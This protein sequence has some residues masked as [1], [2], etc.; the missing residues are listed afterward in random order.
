MPRISTID[1]TK[2]TPESASP[3]AE[4]VRRIILL[5]GEWW[6]PD[7][8]FHLEAT[9]FVSPGGGAEGEIFWTNIDTPFLAP[10]ACGT[11]LVRGAA[12]GMSLDLQGYRI[13]GPLVMDHYLISLVGDAHAGHFEGKSEAHGAWDARLSG[14]YQIV[15]E[16]GR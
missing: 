15:E 12:G 1:R 3:K 7:S 16:N 14:E 13:D 2:P 4:P 6:M 8:R 5:S 10:D 9:I 11:E